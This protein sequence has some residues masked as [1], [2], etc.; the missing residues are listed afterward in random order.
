I[1]AGYLL[2]GSPFTDKAAA[3]AEAACHALERTP[4]LTDA[5]GAI[6]GV[7]LA[8]WT[9][10]TTLAGAAAE[11]DS[12]YVPLDEALTRA[13]AALTREHSAESARFR[14]ELDKAYV[15]CEQ[16]HRE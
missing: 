1:G 5:K 11:Q 2:F 14:L 16:D 13:R 6:T 12:H 3:D 15:F 9:A 8:R 7:A 10:A 4:E